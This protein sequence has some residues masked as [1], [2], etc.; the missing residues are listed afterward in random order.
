MECPIC[1]ELLY[2]NKHIILCNCLHKYHKK[3]YNKWINK[4]GKNQCPECFT[5]NEFY[6]NHNL[7]S[8]KNIK[9]PNLDIKKKDQCAC[10]I[11]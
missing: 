11:S 9:K 4:I 5:I 7:L 2:P 6:I 1:L 8:K 10:I 3:C